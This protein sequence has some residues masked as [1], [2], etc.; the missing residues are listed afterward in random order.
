MPELPLMRQMLQLLLRTA[1]DEALPWSWRSVCLEHSVLPA[2]R[3][4]SLLKWHDPQ[5]A[6]A[7][8]CAVHAARDRL[9]TLPAAQRM[10]GGAA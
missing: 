8:D 6:E 10:G 4:R 2:A 1:H 3:L 9:D 7:V 5:A